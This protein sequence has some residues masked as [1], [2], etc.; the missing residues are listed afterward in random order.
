MEVRWLSFAN[1]LTQILDLYPVIK[2]LKT[3]LKDKDELLDCLDVNIQEWRILA[4]IEAILRPA[5]ISTTF[6]DTTAIPITAFILPL[7]DMLLKAYGM[8]LMKVIRKKEG[9]KE[10]YG[11]QA[12]NNDAAALE[13]EPDIDESKICFSVR[14]LDD[15]FVRGSLCLNS[16]RQAKGSSKPS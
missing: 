2:V 9:K 13:I 7:F 4:E 3:K 10:E 14:D 1:M 5:V 11:D 16:T 12:R 8:S 6:L 15:A